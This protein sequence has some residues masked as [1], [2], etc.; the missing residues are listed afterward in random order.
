M[1]KKKMSNGYFITNTGLVLDEQ[2]NQMAVKENKGGYLTFK[3][4]LV[5]RLVA[6]HF[7]PNPDNLPIVNHI[8]HDRQNPNVKNLEW[9]SHKENSNKTILQTKSYKLFKECYAEYG[10]Q[11]LSNYLESLLKE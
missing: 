10:D 5:H 9:V 11:H 1:L 2:G 6:I 3:G 8:D 7:L 4:E